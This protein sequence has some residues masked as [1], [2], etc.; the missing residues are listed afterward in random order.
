MK[1]A[2]LCPGQ[3]SQMVGMGRALMAQYPV[4][5]EMLSE[6]GER[7][8]LDLAKAVL[9]GPARLLQST[10]VAQVAIFVFSAGVGQV[11]DRA[12]VRFDIAAGHSLGELSALHL[13]G[14]LD[15]SDALNLV[16]ARAE[17]MEHAN[18]QAQGGM[19][20]VMGERTSALKQICAEAGISVC[21]FNTP[22]QTVIS[23]EMSALAKVEAAL[24]VEGYRVQRLQVAGAYHSPLMEPAL[25]IFVAAL[26]KCGFHTPHIPVVSNVT[27]KVLGASDDVHKELLTQ[28]TA[29]V[30]WQDC[31]DTMVAEG[32]TAF[33]EV[34]FGKHMKGLALQNAV[35]VPCFGTSSPGE[36]DTIIETVLSSEVA[37]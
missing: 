31:I 17:A 25:P 1:L 5:D 10:R 16:I 15:F 9:R 34:G 36:I 6:A 23:G 29:P 13:A 19:A 24:K 37:A 20:A 2:M 3:G 4:F 7:M 21:N 8:S 22:T 30:L 18:Q 12:G 35:E 33:V 26:A 28:V 32:A 14:A 27:G 11:L